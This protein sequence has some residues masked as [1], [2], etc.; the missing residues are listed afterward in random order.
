[1]PPPVSLTAACDDPRLLGL[2]LW[3]RQR[4]LLEAVERGPRLHVWCLGRRSGKSLMAALVGVHAC[5]L[6]PELL[7]RL[8]PG[9]RGYAVAIATALRQ[10]RLIVQA[11]PR[12]WSTARYWP[13]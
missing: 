6:R 4:E 7:D 1:M 13:R 12:S 10:A 9:E 3:S 11:A 5:L 8:R 2:E